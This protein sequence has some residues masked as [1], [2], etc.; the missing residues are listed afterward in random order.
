LGR[1]VSNWLHRIALFSFLISITFVRSSIHE[2]LLK[3]TSIRGGV[4]PRNEDV[5]NNQKQKEQLY[6]A[7]NLLHSLAQDFQKPFDSPAVL[8]V[9]HQTSGKSALIEAL[10]GF[11]F[12]QVGGGTKTRRPI[13]LRMQY[14]PECTQPRCYL[15]RDSGREELMT[16]RDIQA[17][18]EGENKRL[19]AD[20][21]RCFDPREINIR[22]EYR[23]CPNMIVIDTPGLLA[24]PSGRNLNNQ[25]RAL[26]QASREAESLVLE[27]MHCKDYIILCVEDTTDWKHASTR[28]IVQQVDPELSRTVL[29]TTKLDTKI[30]QF[31]EAHDLKEFLRAPIMRRLFPALLGGP[32]F[33]SVPSG[34]VGSTRDAAYYTNED[35]VL[36]CR[37]LQGADE[38]QIR[39]R[40]GVHAGKTLERVGV[41][42]L[43]TFL[44][45]RVEEN[46]KRNVAKIVPMLQ[47]EL[48]STEKKLKATV[49]ELD[50]LSVDHL[51]RT[52]DLLKEQFSRTV[53][54]CIQGSIIAPASEYGETLEAEQQ[55]AGA[56][57]NLESMHPD[58]V[59][60]ILQ[61]D[62]GDEDI[63]LYG[64]AQYHR[65]LR[66]FAAAVQNLPDVEVTPEEIANAVGVGDMHDGANFM[67]AACVIAVEKARCAFE[68]LLEALRHRSIHIMKRLFPLAKYIMEHE[69]LMLA[70]TYQ[71]PFNQVLEQVYNQFVDE[72]TES[73]INHCR[74]DLRAITRFVTWDLHERGSGALQRSLPDSNMVEI[75]SMVMGK[76]ARS[77]ASVVEN[78]WEAANEIQHNQIRERDYGDLIQLMEEATTVRDS[79]RT[80][81]V[82]T[83]LVQ[84]ITRAWRG[85]FAQQVATKF[86]C[87][88]LMPFI[89]QLPYYLR[90]ELDRI[91]SDNVE[92][93]FDVTRLR[94]GLE[95]QVDQ[96]KAE[97]EAHRKLQAKFDSI[98]DQL[99]VSTEQ[100]IFSTVPEDEIELEERAAR[101]RIQMMEHLD[102]EE[103]MPEE[104]YE[105]DQEMKRDR[106]AQKDASD[107]M[108]ISPF[109]FDDDETDTIEQR[110]SE[111]KTGGD[112]QGSDEMD[113]L[114][115]YY[116]ALGIQDE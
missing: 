97:C 14:N 81:A 39:R 47:G 103:E 27:K 107:D 57:L 24:P 93:L 10:M 92:D 87:F 105:Y 83:C 44:E 71:R 35:F 33:T 112:I 52:A 34:R 116:K 36:G 106:P 11:Q 37:R 6:E 113:I 58:T 31:G 25:Q 84:H 100:D 53:A 77:S 89:D 28:N 88:F 4:G 51:R 30:P 79:K 61:E 70:D 85:N 90:T 48:T 64:G 45:R 2:R 9:G 102:L 19:E 1:S 69:G 18:I 67:R 65:C 99:E 95:D 75:Y 91:Y 96:L 16:L 72:V 12:N 80:H 114:D 60:D 63:K 76:K 5:S 111:S 68:P 73:S 101:S 108:F 3:T 104:Y 13:A 41:S 26:L 43:R 74:D 40:L 7:Y 98:N 62:V 17:Y 15:T 109:A 29:V 55:R 94:R 46:Y 32:F 78:E 8:V 54:S 115:D 23:F 82:V 20:A 22:M 21:I 66:E 110:Q 86:N 42:N 49:A 50:S 59:M 38:A 56:F